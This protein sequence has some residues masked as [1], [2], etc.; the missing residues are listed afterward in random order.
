MTTTTTTAKK[1]SRLHRS[2]TI[3]GRGIAL[4]IA[5]GAC[6]AFWLAIISFI[7]LGGGTGDNAN[8]VSAL[9]DYV[10]IVTP[11]AM[12]AVAPA[13]ITLT[14]IETT[15]SPTTPGRRFV[16]RV[17]AGTGGVLIWSALL[18]S[19]VDLMAHAIIV[20]L[21]FVTVG[22]LY[23]LEYVQRF[24]T[25]PRSLQAALLTGWVGAYLFPVAVM[26]VISG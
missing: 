15:T 25:A 19:E 6:A 18:L 17:L 9:H 26:W 20:F 8:L 12:V 3:A 21:G 13:V 2:K 23:V 1:P 24:R 22:T 7:W 10:T 11:F 14:A 16:S 4:L 5:A